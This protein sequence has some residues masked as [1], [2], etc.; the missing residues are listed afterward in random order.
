MLRRFSLFLLPLLLA[1]TT[2]SAQSASITFDSHWNETPSVELLPVGGQVAIVYDISRLPQCRGTTSTGSPSWSISGHYQVNRG[3]VQSF[4]V[5]GHS[6]DGNTAPPVLQLPADVKG[7][8]VMWFEISGIG[9]HGWDSNDGHNYHFAIGA[10]TLSFNANWDEVVSGTL[11]A[12][13]ELILNYDLSRL[14]HCRQGYNGAPTWGIGAHY[15]FGGGAWQVVG[16]T[17]N[18]YAH[19]ST[20]VSITVPSTG[21]TF[22][23][24]FKNTDRASCVAYD[25]NQ[26]TNYHFGVQ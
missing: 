20:P 15:R 21:G 11:R 14:P 5:A 1:G 25:S 26:G 7:A 16:V 12:G 10:P 23:V 9:C 17:T 24:Y 4:W 13:Q 8:L 22:E 19:V 2:A 6:P 3:P 18:D